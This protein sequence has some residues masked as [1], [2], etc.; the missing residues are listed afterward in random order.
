M[1][2][3]AQD[4][5]RGYVRIIAYLA[6]KVKYYGIG[7]IRYCMV[8]CYNIPMDS[9]QDRYQQYLD[10]VRKYSKNL[11]YKGDHTKGEI[12]M[13][14]DV[15]LFPECEK[16][17]MERMFK[18]GVTKEDAEKR[19]QIGIFDENRWG[20]SVHEPL[21]LPDGTYTT[22]NRWIS[23]STLD[24]GHA[25]VVVAPFLSD[26][27]LIFIKNFRNATKNWCLEFPRGGKDLGN[28]IIKTVKNELSEEIGAELIEDPKKI[29][30]VFPDSGVLAS[31]VDVFS[32]K[33]KLSGVPEH[34]GTEAIK[35]MVL[36]SK[37]D[38]KKVIEVQKYTDED[39]KI[40]EFKDG[41]TLT[42]L[43]LLNI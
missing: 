38:I 35:G 6:S 43:R 20:V 32:C 40:Y 29:G 4:P 30:E 33:I 36:M 19:A 23:W 27:R 25:G 31:R 13:I 1:P 21:R 41:F 10:F 9:P 34:E 11:G 3:Y 8:L 39:G 15:S 26:G 18:T 7:K 17:A 22:F 2:N 16:G 28:N 24:S 37:D 42:T 14:F 5:P 12:E